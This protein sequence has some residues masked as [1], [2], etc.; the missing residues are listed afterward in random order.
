[1][2]GTLFIDENEGYLFYIVYGRRGG[3]GFAVGLGGRVGGGGLGVGVRVGK[4]G[5]ATTG[6]FAFV[7]ESMVFT[8]PGAK[9]KA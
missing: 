5:R 9:F 8:T 4:A 1:M 2:R 7:T 6:W 3:A